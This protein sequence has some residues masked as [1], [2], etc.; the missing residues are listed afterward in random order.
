MAAMTNPIVLF[1]FNRDSDLS[2]WYIVDDVVM[3]GRSDSYLEVTEEG[4]GRFY[5]KVSLENNGG[6]ASTRHNLGPQ[7]LSNHKYAKLKLK[8]DGKAYQFRLKEST[9]QRF[10]YI[11]SFKT[12]GEWETIKIPL[13][14]MYPSFRGRKL[15]IPNYPATEV[16]EL[17]ILISNKRNENFE[18][19][20]ESIALTK[21]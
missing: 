5:G 20:I 21:E 12:S 7:K 1:E 11:Y 19:L 8:G 4:K 10:S 18:L 15:E 17:A 2:Q 6:F 14:D 16:A 13:S 9:D 3:G